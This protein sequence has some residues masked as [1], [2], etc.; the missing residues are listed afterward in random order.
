MKSEI[1]VF[2][3]PNQLILLRELQKKTCALPALPLCLRCAELKDIKDKIT[4]TEPEEFLI[5]GNRVFIKVGMEVNG[6][7][8]EG[9]IELGEKDY[10]TDSGNSEGMSFPCPIQESLSI[11]KISPFRIVEMETEEFENGTKWKILREKWGKI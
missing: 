6:K 8:C 9:R 10:L 1:V 4:K 11:K 5:E 2:P 7:S 3:N